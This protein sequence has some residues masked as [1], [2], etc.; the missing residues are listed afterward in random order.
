M[1]KTIIVENERKRI[2]E[3]LRGGLRAAQDSYA[4]LRAEENLGIVPQ[5]TECTE[6]W[7]TKI[8]E[9][10]KQA[11]QAATFLTI[12]QRKSQIA[13][14]GKLYKRMLPN[15]QRLQAFLASIP[16][17]RYVYDTALNTFYIHDISSLVRERATKQ[18][19]EEFSEHWQKIQAIRQAITE[20][21]EWEA[22]HGLRKLHIEDLLT[23]TPDSLAITWVDGSIQRNTEIY[24]KP[25]MAN[26][27]AAQRAQEAMY[28]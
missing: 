12:N 27:M 6:D 10:G 21:R 1:P 3:E 25:Y 4:E 20:L 23:F 13:H 24:N 5:P 17:E 2:D 19:P 28:L 15:V 18:V 8:Y 22:A 7:L 11:V 26:V 14:W 16:Q 9:E